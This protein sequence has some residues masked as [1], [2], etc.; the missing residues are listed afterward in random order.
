MNRR[1]LLRGAAALALSALL[2]PGAE[3]AIK[4]CGNCR[5]PNPEG[6]TTCFF[7]KAALK[8]TEAEPARAPSEPQRR[9]S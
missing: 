4:I 1:F 7:C 2:A 5:T 8:L 3:A 6:S 9:R